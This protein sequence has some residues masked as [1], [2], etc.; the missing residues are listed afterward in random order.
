MAGMDS[1]ETITKTQ[2]VPKEYAN[3]W[4]GEMRQD[5]INPVIQVL[6]SHAEAACTQ[7]NDGD[8][9]RIPVCPQCES[10]LRDTIKRNEVWLFVEYLPPH[11]TIELKCVATGIHE[12]DCEYCTEDPSCDTP[13]AWAVFSPEGAMAAAGGGRLNMQLLFAQ[14]RVL[15]A[16]AY[17]TLV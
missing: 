6:L 17:P 2:P 15:P 11:K 3:I 4:V 12:C 9:S 7:S 1:T 5:D 10:H 13:L 14:G 8:E 16:L